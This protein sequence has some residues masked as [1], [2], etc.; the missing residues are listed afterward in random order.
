[1]N[2]ERT[3]HEHEKAH[4]KRMTKVSRVM[5][6]I[7]MR[8]ELQELHEAWVNFEHY[9]CFYRSKRS[10]I[11]SPLDLEWWNG[12]VNFEQYEYRIKQKEHE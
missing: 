6:S 7:A 5:E 10:D 2:T 11:W 4:R 3:K 8:N 1:M 9:E 12:E